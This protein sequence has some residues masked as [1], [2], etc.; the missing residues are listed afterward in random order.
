MNLLH[1]ER[2]WLLAVVPLL[3]LFYVWMQRR[4]RRHAVRFTN[5]DLLR[6]VAPTTSAWRRHVPAVGSAVAIASLVLAFSTPQA[7]AKVPKESAIV[8]LVIDTSASMDATD[9][10]PSRLDAAIDAAASFVEDLPAGHKV[11]LVAFDARADVVATPTTD[12]G[13]VQDAIESLTLGPGTAAGDALYAAVEAVRAAAGEALAGDAAPT[14]EDL[15]EQGAAIVLL[16]DGA[17]TVGRPATVGAQAAASAG[18]PVTAISFGTDEGAVT[19]QGRTVPVP[20]DPDTMAAVADIT[21]GRFFEAFS[22]EDL[23]SVY[24][25]IGTRVGY[26]TQER[27]ASGPVLLASTTVLLASLALAFFWNGRLA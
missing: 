1:P 13:A 26:E 4:S 9:V 16:S 17:T 25:D 23:A 14:A 22:S 11:G 15:A 8:M 24:E 7:T 21:S 2:L 27:D 10:D 19:V 5:V 20:A 18:I 3:A 12:H 6:S